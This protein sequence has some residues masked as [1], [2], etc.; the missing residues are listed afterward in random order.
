VF[1]KAFWKAALERAVKTFAQTL[2]ALLGV[3]SVDARTVDLLRSDWRVDLAVA[4]IAALLSVCFSVV[5]NAST[6]TGPSLAGEQTIAVSYEPQH[7]GD[8]VA[9][10]EA[11][12]DEPPVPDLAARA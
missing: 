6:G 4:G 11:H 9:A 5:S 2:V 1:T 12:Q 10:D 8:D 3:T 7:V